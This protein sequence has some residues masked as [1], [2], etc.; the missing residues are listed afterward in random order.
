MVTVQ[1]SEILT[2]NLET[3][4]EL[5]PSPEVFLEGSAEPEESSDAVEEEEETPLDLGFEPY[6]ESKKRAQ[7]SGFIR[8][9]VLIGD[10]RRI[11]SLHGVRVI[12]ISRFEEIS[13]EAITQP[14]M[15]E[16]KLRFWMN[17]EL[18]STQKKAPYYMLGANERV[19]EPWE[20]APV[21]KKIFIK[22]GGGGDVDRASIKLVRQ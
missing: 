8:D 2:G 15:R 1:P 9:I 10:G 18:I 19:A 16:R 5:V 21:D 3:Y 12:D 7:G 20:N 13:I 14:G 22:V 4:E 17:D 11:S 6:D